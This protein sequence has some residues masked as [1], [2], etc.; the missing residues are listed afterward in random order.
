MTQA[1]AQGGGWDTPHP[2]TSYRVS[3]GRFCASAPG[4]APAAPLGAVSPRSLQQHSLGIRTSPHTTSPGSPVLPGVWPR[5]SSCSS[6]RHTRA[7]RG[8]SRSPWPS[9]P[10]HCPHG[11]SFTAGHSRVHSG[12]WPLFQTLPLTSRRCLLPGCQP[13]CLLAPR[14]SPPRPHTPFRRALTLPIAQPSR[15]ASPIG[16]QS[17]GL[18]EGGTPGAPHPGQPWAMWTAEPHRA[19]QSPA[20]SRPVR[21]PR[22][23]SARLARSPSLHGRAACALRPSCCPRKPQQPVQNTQD[24]FHG[25]RAG[26][27]WAFWVGSILSSQI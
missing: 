24:H 19:P 17:W 15:L 5:P 27:R 16:P 10:R 18:T 6:G 8:S 20:C 1:A 22:G 14:L 26:R 12:F 4:E 13:P 3:W 25:S 23:P 21:L 11:M 9:C 2:T 7:R